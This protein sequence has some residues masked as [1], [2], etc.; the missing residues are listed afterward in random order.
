[1]ENKI[2]YCKNLCGK[3]LS[4]KRSIYCSN[5]CQQDFANK[6]R[7]QQWLD[8]IWDGSGGKYGLSNTIRLYLLNKSNYSCE[9]C[10][11]N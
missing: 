11:W 2:R 6:V 7:I 3:T 9:K 5:S 8:G 1:M 4:N 10:G